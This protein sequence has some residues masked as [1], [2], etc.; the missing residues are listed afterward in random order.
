MMTTL[1]IIAVALI[2]WCFALCVNR[3]PKYFVA[4]I[5]KYWY[6]CYEDLTKIDEVYRVARFDTK[7]EAIEELEKYER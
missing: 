5:G 4:K 3:Q 7:Q 6:I 1:L 2:V